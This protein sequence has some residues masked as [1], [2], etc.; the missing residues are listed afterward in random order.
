M[1]ESQPGMTFVPYLGARLLENEEVRKASAVWC[2]CRNNIS[3][4]LKGGKQARRRYRETT[5]EKGHT[6]VD[7]RLRSLSGTPLKMAA[8]FPSS[9]LSQKYYHFR[10]GP[11]A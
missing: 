1:G 4:P 11:V 10:A 5:A 6:P 2:V 7:R 3:E 9:F 8:A